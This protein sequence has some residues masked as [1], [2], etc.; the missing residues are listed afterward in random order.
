[1]SISRARI[2]AL[3]LEERW[4]MQRKLVVAHD[5][6]DALLDLTILVGPHAYKQ[7]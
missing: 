1:M 2:C 6:I 7:L 4:R 3:F 5:Q